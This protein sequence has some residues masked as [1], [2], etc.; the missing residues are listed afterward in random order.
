MGRNDCRI[1]LVRS[2]F[3]RKGTI[4]GDDDSYQ[5]LLD[6][7]IISIL[8]LRY[9]VVAIV[10]SSIINFTLVKYYSSLNCFLHVGVCCYLTSE[11][12]LIIE[13]A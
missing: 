10:E 12:G 6:T 7:I 11:A 9:A 13:F 3:H 8:H 2:S 5:S 1:S 4:A